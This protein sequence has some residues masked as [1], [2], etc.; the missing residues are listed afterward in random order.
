MSNT[1]RV[2]FLRWVRYGHRLK[3]LQ[4]SAVQAQV[5]AKAAAALKKV[6][7]QKRRSIEEAQSTL[8][9]QQEEMALARKRKEQQAGI[10]RL[11]LEEEAEFAMEKVIV[12]DQELGVGINM[13]ELPDMPE[14]S[15]RRKVQHFITE[16]CN[17]ISQCIDDQTEAPP[18]N[19]QDTSAPGVV[20]LTKPH[21]STVH[22]QQSQNTQHMPSTQQDLPFLTQVSQHVPHNNNQAATASLQTPQVYLQSAVTNTL[23]EGDTQSRPRARFN[24]NAAEFHANNH[25]TQS[26]PENEIRSYVNFMARRELIA[27]KIEKFDDNPVNYHTL[28]ASFN[29]MIR[30][31]QITPSEEFSLLIEYTTLSSK[32]L[33]QRL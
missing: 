31:F 13:E 14:L 30:N 18:V 9:I 17:D 33:V 28:K 8:L 15:A 10:E 20:C 4:S 3:R 2:Y 29:N 21:I 27:N 11:H 5:R 1:R 22:P 7:L 16:Q 26:A 24:P 32:S 19:I 6:E 25:S 12:V 23:P